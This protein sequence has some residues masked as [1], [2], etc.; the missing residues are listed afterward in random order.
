MTLVSDH[1]PGI[2]WL[3]RLPPQRF[4]TRRRARRIRMAVLRATDI[5]PDARVQ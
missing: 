2:G 4:Y 5:Y 3:L 1:Y